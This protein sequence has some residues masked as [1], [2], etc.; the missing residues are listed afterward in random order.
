[1][2]FT[3]FAEL[4]M[5]QETYFEGDCMCFDLRHNGIEGP[6]GL[7]TKTTCNQTT[8]KQLSTLRVQHSIAD[9]NNKGLS[10]YHLCLLDCSH[11]DIYSF[12]SYH[13]YERGGYP[14]FIIHQIFLLA[15]LSASRYRIFSSYDWGISAISKF[16]AP[17]ITFLAF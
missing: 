10:K 9:T 11:S 15:R 12:S 16:S 7:H 17:T 3:R 8:Q 14:R 5:R 1:M 13:S 6:K 2:Q 4:N